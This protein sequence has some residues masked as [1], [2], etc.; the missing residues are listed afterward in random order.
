[1]CVCMC[2]HVRGTQ[3]GGV[4]GNHAARYLNSLEPATLATSPSLILHLKNGPDDITRSQ[5]L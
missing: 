3:E 1:M 4:P 5:L 2:V